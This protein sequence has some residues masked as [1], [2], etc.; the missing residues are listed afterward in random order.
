MVSSGYCRTRGV[1]RCVVWRER[2][3]KESKRRQNVKDQCEARR[4]CGGNY[5]ISKVQGPSLAVE[6][7][8]RCADN[9]GAGGLAKASAR[10][11]SVALAARLR[12]SVQWGE[13]E[14]ES[15]SENKRERRRGVWARERD[16][17]RMRTAAAVSQGGEGRRGQGSSSGT[18]G[19]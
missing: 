14:G 3:A 17:R 2:Q 6:G 10:C 19:K 12:E 11:V 4:S 15:E 13:G 8:L 1:R 9:V 16:A 18:R 7:W 5:E